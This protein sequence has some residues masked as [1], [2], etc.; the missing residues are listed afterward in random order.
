MLPSPAGVSVWFLLNTSLLQGYWDS[1]EWLGVKCVVAV[2]NSIE[3]VCSFCILGKGAL[4]IPPWTEI[5][6]QILPWVQ[7]GRAL[8]HRGGAR[9]WASLEGKVNSTP[10]EL[11]RSLFKAGLARPGLQCG[12]WG[13]DFLRG[14]CCDEKNP[15]AGGKCSSLDLFSND[16]NNVVSFYQLHHL[17]WQGNLNNSKL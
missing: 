2:T 11:K 15:C 9:A 12:P 13:G 5:W 17:T 6:F 4:G 10:E 3:L 8:E 14:L 16:I 7:E 1:T